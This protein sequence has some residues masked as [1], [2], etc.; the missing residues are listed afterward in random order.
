MW[1]IAVTLSLALASMMTSAQPLDPERSVVGTTV[2]STQEP[3]IRIELPPTAK[4]L[5]A[6]R[7][8]LGG[9]DDCEMHLFAEADASRTI[10]RF[11]WV[12]FEAYVPE[13]PDLH[14][15][16]D[17]SRHLTLG[18]IDFYLDTWVQGR[19]DP[20]TPES[21]EAHAHDVISAKGYHL[22]ADG[23]YVRLVHLPDAAK[24][25][26]VMII[27][28]EDLAPTGFSAKQL[29]K[30]GDTHEKWAGIEKALI[31]RAIDRIAVFP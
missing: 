2:R 27:Y 5:G 26:E 17:G 28:A 21:D 31:Q 16:Y 30:H 20:I 25:H 11:Y 24:R 29:G 6:D 15:N 10:Q 19:A 1:K 8:I 7:W 12:Q 23:M 18:G 22:P 3:K 9:Y 4:Y 13:K 14:H